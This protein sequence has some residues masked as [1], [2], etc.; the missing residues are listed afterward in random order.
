M[1]EI[2]TISLAH[3]SK[4]NI[5]T[6]KIIHSTRT[7]ISMNKKNL[8]KVYTLVLKTSDGPATV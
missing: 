4:I 7:A 8:F 6:Y 3:Y 2:N 5:K 1:I